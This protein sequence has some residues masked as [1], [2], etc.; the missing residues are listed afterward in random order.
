MENVRLFLSKKSQFGLVE[1][2]KIKSARAHHFFNLQRTGNK[3][4]FYVAL[5]T[6]FRLSAP[7]AS[8]NKRPPRVSAHS[9]SEQPPFIK[10]KRF[11]N[12]SNA[13]FSCCVFLNLSKFAQ[14]LSS[15]PPAFISN[16][17]RLTLFWFWGKFTPCQTF[18][19]SF[20]SEPPD[21]WLRFQPP[22]SCK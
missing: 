4:F 16:C 9:S 6:P 3:N 22:R 18:S 11:A 17:Y 15:N 21:I 13:W 7:R 19:N 12:V 10:I 20:F 1:K 5:R 2:I 14:L 8:W